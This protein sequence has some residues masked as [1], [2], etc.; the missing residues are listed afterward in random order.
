MFRTSARIL[1]FGLLY[2]GATGI[3]A[4]RK[5]QRRD[6]TPESIKEDK[7]NL[8]RVA[9]VRYEDKTGSKNFEYMPDSLTDAIDKSLQRRFE[10]QRENPQKTAAAISAFKRKH[11][12]IDADD[13]VDFCRMHKTDILILGRFEFDAARNEIVVKTSISMGVQVFFRKLK[14]RHNP[15]D[16]TVFGLADLVADDIVQMLVEIARDQVQKK[17]AG[18][19]EEKLQLYRSQV[20]TWVEPNWNVFAGGVASL[21]LNPSFVNYRTIQPQLSLLLERR[22]YRKVFLGISVDAARTRAAGLGMD[23]FAGAALIGYH[24][25]IAN[26][27]DLFVLMGGGY[28]WGK[29]TNTV[30]CSAM[31]SNTAGSE[32][33]SIYNPYATSRLG[34]NFL[35]LHWLSLS[36][37]VQGGMF[38]DKP[39]PLYFAG[40]GLAVGLH[41]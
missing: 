4:I 24:W 23:L 17:N 9:I 22:V 10:Y 18:N 14:D 34:V 31:C 39:T 12:E 36:L 19:K 2:S 5:A 27:W 32:S 26:R 41:F 20:V 25:H 6:G 33:L 30:A 7:S 15:V 38:F 35:M 28:Y 8:A 1:V 11:P 29:Y 40:G 3:Y 21:P 16:A 37:F 13:A